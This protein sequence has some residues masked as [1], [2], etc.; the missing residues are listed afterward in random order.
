MATTT[1]KA[2]ESSPTAKTIHFFEVR[3]KDN[4][5]YRVFAR[6]IT[7][8]RYSITIE[9]NGQR[10]VIESKYPLDQ[11][12]IGGNT[13]LAFVYK[14]KKEE[15]AQFYRLPQGRNTFN[16]DIDLEFN[17]DYSAIR[18]PGEHFDANETNHP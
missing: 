17:Y 18:T 10:Y 5:F 12:L 13:L 4:R 6:L 2:T 14:K 9:R 8:K 15:F 11:M 16:P 3:E 1:Q 7:F